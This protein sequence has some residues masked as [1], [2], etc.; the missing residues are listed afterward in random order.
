MPSR[1]QP[2]IQKMPPRNPR[3]GFLA[4]AP[5]WRGGDNTRTRPM[6]TEPLL[7]LIPAPTPPFLPSSAP[8]QQLSASCSAR[9]WCILHLCLSP[10]RCRRSGQSAPLLPALLP[11]PLPSPW[12]PGDESSTSRALLPLSH[13][14]GRSPFSPVPPE[15]SSWVINAKIEAAS[16]GRR[17]R[18]GYEHIPS[19]ASSLLISFLPPP[20]NTFR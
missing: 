8:S 16:P 4:A 12:S 5:A 9:T 10:S 3:S 2:L 13:P 11:L 14:I 6:G 15:P 18:R 20:K 7:Q 1:R 19:P 17:P